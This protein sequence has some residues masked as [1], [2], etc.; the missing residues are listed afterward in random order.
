MAALLIDVGLL[1]VG[2]AVFAIGYAAL[3]VEFLKQH[4]DNNDDW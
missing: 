4:H 3:T 1:F 2:S